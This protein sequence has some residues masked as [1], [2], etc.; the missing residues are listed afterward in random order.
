MEASRLGELV[1]RARTDKEF[2]ANAV[3]DL[4]GTLTANGYELSEDEL[5]A[6]RLFH[7]RAVELSDEELEEELV[8]DVMGHG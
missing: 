7:A 2:R 1:E 6:V 5:E 3:R 4:E 8:G